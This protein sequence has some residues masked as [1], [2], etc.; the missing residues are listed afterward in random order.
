MPTLSTYQL[1]I[2]SGVRLDM[3]QSGPLQLDNVFDAKGSRPLFNL[4]PTAIESI[5]QNCLEHIAAIQIHLEKNPIA[6]LSIRA[7][8]SINCY[9]SNLLTQHSERWCHLGAACILRSSISST[10]CGRQNANICTLT[11]T[12]IVADSNEYLMGHSTSKF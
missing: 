7:P 10:V 5:P 9:L 4:V 11:Q 3:D 8:D 12:S 2:V 1:R 6:Y